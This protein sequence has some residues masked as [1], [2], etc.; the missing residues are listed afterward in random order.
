MKTTYLISSLLALLTLGSCIAPQD[1]EIDCQDCREQQ[2]AIRLASDN[3]TTRT[4][5]PLYSNQPQQD[6]DRVM[7]IFCTGNQVVRKKPIENWMSNEVSEIYGTNDGS[8]GRQAVVKLEGADRLN[9]STTYT[10]YAIAYTYDE[11]DSEHQTAYT[12]NGENLN[13]YLEDLSTGTN[14]P[15]NLVLTLS[16]A[17]G[18]E[19]FA[20]SAEFTTNDSGG[21]YKP[22]T[23]NRQVAGVYMY[24]SAIPNIDQAKE[25]RLTAA[26]DNDGLVL[27]QFD[28]KDYGQDKEE[29]FKV[30]NG[31]TPNTTADANGRYTL[32]TIDFKDWKNGDGS[33]KNPYEGEASFPNDSYFSGSF[34]IPF[35]AQK[36]IQSLQMELIGDN[37]TIKEW[38]VNLP[39]EDISTEIYTWSDNGFSINSNITES[40]SSYCLLRNHLYCIGSKGTDGSTDGDEPQP[41]DTGQD[42][43]L[44]VIAEWDYVYDIMLEPTPEGSK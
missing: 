40:P 22:I 13:D 33:W 6:V 14:S 26:T 24:V 1:E 43:Q 42:I 44:K 7:L 19:I 9:E 36:D 21:F 4:G 41:L 12:V 11:N 37:G 18:E 5:R 8:H 32:C 39:E 28:N 10:V 35:A 15:E 23:L 25:L 3:A 17:P 20:G 34:V 16:E 29:G 31:T 38:N 27:G 30:V 2:I